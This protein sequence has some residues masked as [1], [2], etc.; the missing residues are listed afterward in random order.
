M[1]HKFTELPFLNILDKN[2]N[3]QVITDIYHKP[4]NSPQYLHF[5]NHHP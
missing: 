3:D 2:Q 4:Q 5:K 1:E